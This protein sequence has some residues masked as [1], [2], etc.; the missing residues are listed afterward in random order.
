MCM[1]SFILIG[2]CVSGL[3]GHPVVMYGLRLFVIVLQELRC[4]P[5]T[6][7]ANIVEVIDIYQF[8]KFHPLTL[9]GL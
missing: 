2:C 6:S 9:F 7:Y 5:T 4:L 1:P 3:H 8:T